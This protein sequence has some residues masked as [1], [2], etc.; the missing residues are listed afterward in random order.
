MVSEI[1][2]RY[3]FHATLRLD[4]DLLRHFTLRPSSILE[5]LRLAPNLDIAVSRVL[6]E[7]DHIPRPQVE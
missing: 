2:P 4:G 7:L 6:L 3:H 1:Q 5:Q